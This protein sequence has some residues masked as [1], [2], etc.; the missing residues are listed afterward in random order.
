MSAF[1]LE[2]GVVYHTYSTYARGLD[3]LWGMYQWLDR[4]PKGRNETGLWW[5]RHD[6]YD[7][8]WAKA[9]QANLLWRFS[10]AFRGADHGGGPHLGR[11]VSDRASSR[12][13]C[14]PYLARIH[15]LRR[16]VRLLRGYVVARCAS[17]VRVAAAAISAFHAHREVNCVAFQLAF[18]VLLDLVAV[19]FPDNRERHVIAVDLS[20]AD[21]R[22]AIPPADGSRQFGPVRF[23]VHVHRHGVPFR[24]CVSAVHLPWHR[25][26]T[27]PLVPPN[28]AKSV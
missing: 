27:A 16:R 24:P 11:V 23:Q 25:P 21:V 4:A 14:R 1:A 12:V 18:I 26:P 28:P 6:E 15:D 22:V 3:G 9:S 7:K 10:A 5:R 20:V 19:E 2:D 8:R 13:L 17:K